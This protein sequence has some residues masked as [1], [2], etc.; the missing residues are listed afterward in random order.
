TLYFQKYFPL[1]NETKILFEFPFLHITL[2]LLSHLFKCT[3]P[4]FNPQFSFD[5]ESAFAFRVKD[6]II[7]L[8]WTPK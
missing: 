5:P 7:T 3:N 4:L 1:L 6:W 2:L 8:V